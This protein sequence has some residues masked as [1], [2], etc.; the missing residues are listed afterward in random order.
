MI[1]VSPRAPR[2]T[3][4]PF[5]RMVV[6]RPPASTR[7]VN[8]RLPFTV[9]VG[10]NPEAG[11][12]PAVTAGLPPPFPLGPLPPRLLPALSRLKPLSRPALGLPPPLPRLL[13]PALPGLLLPPL[14][15]PAFDVPIRRALAI[16][17]A[18]VGIPTHLIAAHVTG[19]LAAGAARI[20]ITAGIAAGIATPPLPRLLLAVACPLSRPAF[21]FPP[22]PVPCPR[23]DCP[24]WAGIA[25]SLRPRAGSVRLCAGAG[26]SS[27]W[28]F[29]FSLSFWLHADSRRPAT[30][31]RTGKCP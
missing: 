31:T 7:P 27:R 1:V 21:G 13:L 30:A 26:R 9:R 18:R 22:L 19:W 12:P 6:T 14:L 24:G 15:F 10:P 3:T 23:S 4:R 8:P 25:I 16:V 20:G 29:S 5:P 28:F 17:A 11:L 2:F